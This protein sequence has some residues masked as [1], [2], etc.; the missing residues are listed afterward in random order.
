M[1][2]QP[3]NCAGCM[4]YAQQSYTPSYTPQ[5]SSSASSSSSSASSIDSVVQEYR[6]S[7]KSSMSAPTAEVQYDTQPLRMKQVCKTI[8]HSRIKNIMEQVS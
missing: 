2:T 7:H 5:Y 3:Y 1:Y 8:S 4:Q 6:G